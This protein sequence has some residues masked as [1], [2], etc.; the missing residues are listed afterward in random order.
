MR[1]LGLCREEAE[2]LLVTMAVAALVAA[3]AMVLT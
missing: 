1:S 2:L 3:V